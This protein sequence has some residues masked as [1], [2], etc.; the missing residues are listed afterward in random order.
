MQFSVAKW[1][2]SSQFLFLKRETSHRQSTC[3][4][5]GFIIDEMFDIV[6]PKDLKICLL[7][8]TMDKMISEISLKHL[9]YILVIFWRKMYFKVLDYIN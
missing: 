3:F 7:G 4:Q 8:M 1:K 9:V 5:I 2:Q 6:L